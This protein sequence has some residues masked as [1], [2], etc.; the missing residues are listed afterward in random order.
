M[1]L[2]RHHE[3]SD[4][5]EERLE[6]RAAR[7]P[8][9]S[10]DEIHRLDEVRP[11]VDRKDLR[12]AA[13]LFDR[14]IAREARAAV[15]L[16]GL[17]AHAE[18]LI[19]AVRF[20]ERDEKIDLSLMVGDLPLVLPGVHLHAVDV[21]RE[22]H[23]EGANSLNPR[24]HVE[25]HPPHVGVLD[26]RNARCGGVFPVIDRRALL[27]LPSVLERIQEGR[28]GHA[29]ALN[30]DGNARAVH[31]LEHL[32]HALIEL[33]VAA[34]GVPDAFSVVAEVEDA[35]RRS[36]DAHLVLDVRDV[37][38]VRF[39]DRAVRAHPELGDDEERE[40]FGAGGSAFDAR[41]HE[42]NDVFGEIVVTAGNVDLR[43]L[44]RVAAVRVLHGGGAARADVAARLRLGEAHGAAPPSVEAA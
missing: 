38:V 7:L 26:D 14:K 27:S 29:D 3:L 33:A 13:V 43:A 39:A 5:G 28:G 16:D 37:N 20:D 23:G 9:L 22:L 44:D 17:F 24:L 41:E 30:S 32:R 8:E 4:V 11:F 1:V 15:G 19:R 25:E 34:H 21:V 42:M 10:P 40:A 2:V 6:I 18:G 31:H 12:V 35:G 36:V